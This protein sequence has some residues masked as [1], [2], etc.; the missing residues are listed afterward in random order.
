MSEC[1]QSPVKSTRRVTFGSESVK[2]KAH[3]TR[4]ELVREAR[5]EVSG[6]NTGV[7]PG[8]PHIGFMWF[9]SVTSE[10]NDRAVA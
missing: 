5:R 3:F 1:P 10:S 7:E 9:R 2:Y 4:N 6:S 8:C